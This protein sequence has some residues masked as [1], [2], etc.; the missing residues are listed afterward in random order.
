MSK[1][2][3]KYIFHTQSKIVLLLNQNYCFIIHC[4]ECRE[5]FQQ[6]ATDSNYRVV[7]LSAGGRLFTAGKDYSFCLVELNV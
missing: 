4:R 3:K 7:V 1:R 2:Q 6:L 5:C